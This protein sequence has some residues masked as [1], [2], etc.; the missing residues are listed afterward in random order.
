MLYWLTDTATSSAYV[1][2][3]DEAGRGEVDEDSGVPTGVLVFAHDVGIRRYSEAE[4][5]IVRWTDVEG[6][7]GHFAALEEP[8]LLLDDVRV[9]FADLR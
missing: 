8:D 3:V 5:T 4:N 6:R 7:G 9:F 1:G 2:Y